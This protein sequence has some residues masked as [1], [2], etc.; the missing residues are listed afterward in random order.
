M[1][2][3]ATGIDIGSRTALALKGSVKGNTFAVSDFSVGSLPG[4]KSH[5]VR[6][7][8]SALAQ[9]L[10][11]KAGATRVG[12]TGPEVNIRYTRVPRVPDW[13]L[14]KLMRFEVEEVGGS[15][16]T[17]VASDFNV[18]PELPE[19]EGEDVVLLAMAKESLLGDHQDG[20][21][22]VGG[23]FEA[24][25]P[26][27]I[28]LYNAW[29]RYGVLLDDTVL[30]ANIGHENIDVIIARGQDLLFARSLGGGSKLFDEAIA[31][32]MGISEAEAEE[33]K[34]TL[35]DLTPDVHHGSPD[36]EKAS[37]ACMGPAGQLVGLL[38][39]T[40]MFCKSQVK[41]A[42]LELDRVMVCGG[43][44]AMKGFTS[45]EG[46]G[47][48][49]PCE[50]FD[51]FQVV[52]LGGL[53]PDR[54]AELEEYKLEAVVALGLATAASDPEAYS[55]EILP[56]AL[57]KKREFLGGTAFLIAASIAAVGYLGWYAMGFQTMLGKLET[58]IER[59]EKQYRTA[60]RAHTQAAK[61]VEENEL[62]SDRA[63][64]LFAL[65]GGG[66]QL[67]RVADIIDANM[68]KG[69]WLTKLVSEEASDDDLG[70]GREAR[71]PIVRLEGNTREGTERVDDRFEELVAA[72]EGSLDGLV[73]KRS[74]SSGGERFVIELSTLAPG[75]E[76]VP[77][78]SGEDGD[79]EEA[80]E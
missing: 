21:A 38:S 54:A 44:A 31:A 58:R 39:S 32:R 37:R 1:A 36:Q 15:S 14:R 7:G 28:G 80:G 65:A 34:Q 49:V 4:G 20:V 61:L 29:L 30:V 8:W 66:E 13:Q 76:G 25:T 46:K 10:D 11:F 62:L 64:E 26:N 53:D 78:L 79:D 51:A 41:L 63:V 12:L 73:L 6:A 74:L 16:G 42:G 69:F 52:D 23:A 22:A 48:G 40:V 72:I 70:I 3:Q 5:G 50:E 9:G 43:G 55:I 67:A 27:A 47:L 45:Y 71:R 2:R 17:D 59:A 56:A 19:I 57:H 68:P 77:T 75:Q 24:A 35:V 18:L 60:S 33:L